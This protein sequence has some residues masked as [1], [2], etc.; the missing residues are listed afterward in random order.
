M[1]SSWLLIAV[2]ITSE[3]PTW[4]LR[5]CE[6]PPSHHTHLLWLP[7]SC[8]RSPGHHSGSCL[9][10]SAHAALTRSCSPCPG[11]LGLLNSSFRALLKYSS[12]DFPNL[13]SLPSPWALSQWL[14]IPKFITAGTVVPDRE[15]SHEGG[16][17]QV[18]FL[19]TQ[20]NAGPDHFPD[21][22]LSHLR[23]EEF[24]SPREMPSLHSGACRIPAPHCGPSVASVT[25]DP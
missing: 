2:R 23:E 17:G 18:P 14:W 20:K 9:G 16:G 25:A 10:G 7:V 6:N 15:V 12:F 19:V 4:P 11:P 8:P 21:M 3:I 22:R 13:M 1:I 24:G 5:V